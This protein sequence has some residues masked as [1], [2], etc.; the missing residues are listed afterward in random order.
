MGTVSVRNNEKVD[1][2]NF[3]PDNFY[4]LDKISK[5]EIFDDDEKDETL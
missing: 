3:F 1:K 2:L 5:I 4:M